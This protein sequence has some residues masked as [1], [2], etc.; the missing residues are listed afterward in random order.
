M[1]SS[2]VSR[3][4]YLTSIALTLLLVVWSFAQPTP[5]PD[6][7]LPATGEGDD[8]DSALSTA[9]TPHVACTITGKTDIS[10]AD[11][12]CDGI[13]D[14]LD[15]C[16]EAPEKVNHYRD[17]DGCPDEIPSDFYDPDMQMQQQVQ[18]QEVIEAHRDMKDEADERNLMLLRKLLDTNAEGAR[19]M[20]EELEKLRA[21][22]APPSPPPTKDDTPFVFLDEEEDEEMYG[23]WE[24]SAEEA[25]YCD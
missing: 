1:R 22:N 18:V 20:I 14:L 9:P 4:L 25:P 11:C 5:N 12:D 19:V 24:D 7:T 10:V 23:P 6:L 8:D 15:D 17:Y 21:A 2:L 3:L 16:L 13:P